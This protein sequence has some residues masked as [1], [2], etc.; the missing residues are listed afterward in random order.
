MDDSALRSQ[1]E[2]H[3]ADSY[4]WALACCSQNRALAED[5]LQT[6]YL[7]ILQGRARWRGDAAFKTWLFGVIRLTAADERR[8]FWRRWLGLSSYKRQQ[9]SAVETPGDEAGDDTARFDAF[10]LALERLPLRQREVMHLIFYQSLTLQQA[11]EVMSI[12]LGS[13]RTHY[14][15]AKTNLRTW[16]GKLECFDEYGTDRQQIPRAL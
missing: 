2:H 11:A 4:G 16:L 1:L 13:V 12:S 3:H 8:R 9:E 14:D 10:H 15:R 7:K 5:I 6:A